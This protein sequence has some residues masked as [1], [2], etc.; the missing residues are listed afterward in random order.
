[1]ALVAAPIYVA[2]LIFEARRRGDW[3]LWIGSGMLAGLI[4]VPWYIRAYVLTGNPVFPFLNGIFRSSQWAPIN[5]NFNFDLFGMG[6]QPVD[7]ALLPWRLTFQTSHF[8]EVPD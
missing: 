4:G 1:M 6:H 3:S 2:V 8:A 5:D 7:F